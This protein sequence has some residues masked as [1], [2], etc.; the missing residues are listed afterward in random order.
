MKCPTC[1]FENDE[2]AEFCENCGSSLK[3]VC[4]NCQASLKPGARFCKKCGTPVPET[5]SAPGAGERLAQ[6]QQSAPSDLKEKIRSSS[7]LVEGERKPVTILFTDIVGSTSLAEK[8]DAEEWKE[9]VSSAHQRISRMVYKYEGTIAQLLGDGVLAF[10]G[11]PVTHEDDPV[12]AVHAALDIQEEIKK[13]ADELKGYVDNFQLRIGLNS[14]T[15]VVGNVGSD[16]HME[17][18]AIGDA[19][20]LA[21]RLQSAAQP[22]GVLISASTARFVKAVFDLRSIG[23]IS[24]KGKA[25]PVAAYEVTGHKAVPER[26][27]GFAELYSPLV[28]RASELAELDEALEALHGGHGQIVAVIGEAGI[29]KS[30]LAE[31]ARR[32]DSTRASQAHWIEGRALSYGQSLSFWAITQLVFSDLGLSDGDPEVR[33]RAALKRRLNALFGEKDREIYPYLAHLLGVRLEGADADRVSQLDGETIKRQML[34]ALS[35]YFQRMAEDQPTVAVLEDLHWADSSSLEALEALL[36]VTDRAPLMMLLLARPEREHGAWRVKLRAETDFSHRYREIMLNPLSPSAQNSLVDNLLAVA[37]LPDSTRQLILD[38]TEGNPFYLEEVIRSLIDQGFILHEEGGW[39]ATQNLTD[40]TIP[41]TLEGVLLARIDRLQEDVRRTLQKASVIGKSFLYRLLEAIATAE[42]QLDQQLAQLQRVDLV[43]EKN[44]QPE[45]EY[46]FKHSLTQEAAYNSLLIEQRREFHRRVGEAMETIFSDRLEQY[47][48]LLAHHFEAG[49]DPVKAVRYLIQAGDRARLTDEH[50]E[51]IAYYLRAAKLLEGQPEERL[52]QVW[53]KLGLI[54]QVNFQFEA[55]HQAYEKAFTLQ[56]EIQTHKTPSSEARPAQF[57]FGHYNRHVTIDP[58]K[59]GWVQDATIATEIFTGLATLDEDMDV[60]PA[61]ARSWQVL[62]GGRRYVFHLRDDVTW[63]DGKPVTAEDFEWTWKRNLQPGLG[64]PMA[65]FLF[66]IVGA[67]AYHEGQKGDPDSVGVHALDSLTLEVKMVEPVAYFPFIITMPITLPL[68]RRTIEKYGM[69]WWQ[70]ATIVT[71][72]P[73]RLEMFDRQKGYSL[74][75]NPGYFGDFPGNVDHVEELVLADDDNE[76]SR[77]YLEGRI[78]CLLGNIRNIPAEVP[79]EEV[80][81]SYGLGVFFMV[82]ALDK[83]PF[84]DVRVR[85][86][87]GFSFDHQR[88]IEYSPGRICRGGLVPPG[89]PGH[90]PDICLPYDP[91]MARKLL[92]EAG[93]PGGRGFPAVKGVVPK[94]IDLRRYDEFVRQWRENLNVEISLEE[95]EIKPGVDYHEDLAAS[96]FFSNGWQADYPDPDNF[97]RGSDAISRL[98]HLGWQDPVYDQLVEEASRAT[99]R[100]KRLALYRQADHLL[101]AEQALVLPT[102]Y[103][104]VKGLSKPWVRN[105]RPNPLGILRM[106]NLVI[107]EH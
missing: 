23:E 67:Q 80:H 102:A 10:F 48:G 2:D 101:V 103:F 89:M 78:D 69:D 94:G 40:I 71:N 41:E 85:K 93:Y 92:A 54:Y 106:E 5:H 87:F 44:R 88:F 70:P 7:A 90:S 17:Y 11:A 21:A 20:N 97:L 33:V 57:R 64:A 13:Y 15:V 75:R 25:N 36:A 68:P 72:G 82:Y 42:Q 81:E 56:R 27:R 53:L 43:R 63:S 37:D 4:S 29:G 12:R 34:I 51:A 77:I 14:G 28:G 74:V 19:V 60:V 52:V 46:I 8:L 47:L 105:F 45:L 91:E 58:G 9:I 31:E 61:V 6:L 100:V 1:G 65:G 86:A 73:Y 98:K 26:S 22:G 24:V 59:V 96:S 16:L 95:I 62:E 79:G 18:L 32:Q 35:Q 104:N 30:R 55:A 39:R 83:P 107:Q 3:R 38:R 66:D 99:D 49:G 50:S 84:D 76:L